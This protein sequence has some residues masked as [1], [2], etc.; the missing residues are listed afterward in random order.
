[1]EA[2][3]A[4]D[5]AGNIYGSADTG[6][7]GPFPGDG[8]I[9]KIP[10]GT[11]TLQTIVQFNG[12]NGAGSDGDLTLDAAGN[13][14]GNTFGSIWQIPAGTATLKTVWSFS[15]ANGGGAS[16]CSKVTMDSQGNLYGDANGGGTYGVGL[17]WSLDHAM[18]GDANLDGT[19][20]VGDLGVL[21]TNYGM[22]SGAD[23]NQ[24]DFDG[25]GTVDVGDLGTLATNYGKSGGGGSAQGSTTLSVAN[26]SMT[27]SSPK[28]SVATPLAAAASIFAK[29]PFTDAAW[30]AADRRH[31]HLKDV[32]LA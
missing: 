15:A 12:T 2:S 21:A 17:V 30:D 14:W 27:A 25:N 6:G 7:L 18:A 16:P 10:A 31:E 28:D 1:M 32:G 13:L 22:T 29:V 19:V 3:V 26:T 24:G 8:S 5:S 4:V 20:N 23:W 11:S 9:F